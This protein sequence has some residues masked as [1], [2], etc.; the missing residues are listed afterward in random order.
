VNCFW[1]YSTLEENSF[2][3][4]WLVRDAFGCS[5]VDKDGTQ[6]LRNSSWPVLW[7]VPRSIPTRSNSAFREEASGSHE[8]KGR[9]SDSTVD[10][11]FKAR[12][13]P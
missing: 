12:L 13:R 2:R 10:L 1:S 11:L 8:S 3:P 6:A 4:L 9:N 5:S 7:P